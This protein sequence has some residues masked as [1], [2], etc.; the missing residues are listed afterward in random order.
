VDAEMEFSKDAHGNFKSLALY[1][2]GREM[3]GTKK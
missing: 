1:Q 2:G 3:K